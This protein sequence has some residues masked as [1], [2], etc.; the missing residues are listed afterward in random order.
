MIHPSLAL[1]KL[2]RN[3]M[4]RLLGRTQVLPALLGLVLVLASSSALAQS[5]HLT[6]LTSDLSGKAPHQDSLLKNAWGLAY[7]P[8]APFWVSDEAD[9]WSTLYDGKG[10]PQSLQVII[11]SANGSAPGTPT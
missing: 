1:H 10:N 6:Y 8:N 4:Q 5:Y 9:G 3:R 2:R 11:P 7:S